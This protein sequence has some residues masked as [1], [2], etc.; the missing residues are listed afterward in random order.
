MKARYEVCDF[1]YLRVDN[2]IGPPMLLLSQAQ[3]V[4]MRDAFREVVTGLI[5]GGD[6]CTRPGDPTSWGESFLGRT[7][8]LNQPEPD[9]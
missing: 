5:S 4:H 9:S 1:S 7:G 8:I 6:S 2:P 3:D